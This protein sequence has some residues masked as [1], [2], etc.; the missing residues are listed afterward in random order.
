M[1]QVSIET[2]LTLFGTLVD[3]YRNDQLVIQAP[4]RAYHDIN[5]MQENG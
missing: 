3:Y 5:I 1:F 2:T 4:L